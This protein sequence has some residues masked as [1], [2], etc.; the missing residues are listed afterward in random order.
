M[1]RNC[2]LIALFLMG[3]FSRADAAAPGPSAPPLPKIVSLRLE[4][5]SLSFLNGRDERRVLVIGEAATGQRID[6]TGEAR[7]TAQAPL[8]EID[9]H[10]ALRPKSQGEMTIL[11]SAAG[12]TANLPVKVADATVPTIGFVRDVERM[13][14]AGLARGGSVENCIVLDDQNVISGALRFKDEFVR[15]KILDLLGDLALIGRPILGEIT[16]SRA[17]HALH[18]KFVG[19]I[20]ETVAA[21]E[22]DEPTLQP[23]SFESF[24]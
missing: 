9:E 4:P 21:Q 23:G 20:L 14:A 24:A 6:L 3:G 10:N 17:G 5:P 18:S 11:V 16:A 8:V 15:H 7:L 13:R 22:A 1:N 12:L 2:L 19:K